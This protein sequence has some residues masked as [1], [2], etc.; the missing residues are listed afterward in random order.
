MSRTQQSRGVLAD[1]GRAAGR[2][3]RAG[4]GATK[5]ADIIQRVEQLRGSLGLSKSRFARSMGL[6]PQTYNNFMGPQASKPSVKLIYGIVSAYNVTAMW[7]LNGSGPMF[8]GDAATPSASPLRSQT[9]LGLSSDDTVEGLE[10]LARTR[11]IRELAALAE[12]LRKVCAMADE[13]QDRRAIDP[14][15]AAAVKTLVR[16]FRTSPR[17]T[18]E[19]L[20]KALLDS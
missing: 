15:V 5:F 17:A 19:C 3:S 6:T 11:L 13:L 9:K 10:E 12:S 16:N 2:S 1:K 7:L 18:L 14:S 8:M 20:T 4:K